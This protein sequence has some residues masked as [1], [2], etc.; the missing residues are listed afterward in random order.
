MWSEAGDEGR[1]AVIRGAEDH[2]GGRR[3]RNN[4][5]KKKRGENYFSQL[6]SCVKKKH[7][8]MMDSAKF[9]V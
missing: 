2:R 3:G 6:F 1:E 8:F 9:Y 4:V 5:T 7:C